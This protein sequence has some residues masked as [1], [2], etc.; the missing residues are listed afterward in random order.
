MK[1]Y[2]LFFVVAYVLAAAGST[3]PYKDDVLLEVPNNQFYK[4]FKKS[5]TIDVWEED[6]KSA[7]I[8]LT[9]AQ[10]NAFN[11]VFSRSESDI[12]VLSNNVQEIA[13][14]A[15]QK[16]G[17]KEGEDWFANYHTYEDIQKWYI[18]HSKNHPSNV[19]FVPSIGKTVHNKEIFAVH[20]S[21]NNTLPYGKQK[22]KIWFQSLIHAR[23]WLGGSTTQ[24]IF[25]EFL[26]NR[27]SDSAIN[28]ILNENEIIFIPVS[29]PDGYIYSR[30][31]RF[32]RKNRNQVTGIDINRNF[33][34]RW[35]GPGAS[36][37]PT[38]DDY[39]GTGPASELETQAITQYF[40]KQ[41]YIAG[42]IDF[43]T[44][45]ELV[46]RPPGD[47]TDDSPD[48]A[49]LKELGDSIR[50]VIKQSRGTEYTSEKA[51]ELYPASGSAMDWFYGEGHTYG[52]TIELSPKKSNNI[53][54]FAPPPSFIKPVGAELLP[55][56]VYF[57]KYVTSNPL[58]G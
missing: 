36:T 24:Y 39:R 33:P 20:L 18:N 4:I 8:H 3:G 53:L 2:G 28:K 48:E 47:T 37:D 14:S 57:I 16:D 11:E 10:Y 29:N 31:Y 21:N 12:K 27:D 15:F 30:I 19:K 32:W 22:N 41:G 56:A 13:D 38:Q 9:R 6:H 17:H 43:H 50:D 40:T 1:I 49:K 58:S 5:Q 51:S 54:D 26:N 34:Y 42:A 55:A 23:E 44:F 46:L 52:Y 25:N 7:I 35:G 45:S